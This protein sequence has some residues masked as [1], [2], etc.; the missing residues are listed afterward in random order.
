MFCSKCGNKISDNVNFCSKCGNKVSIA[1]KIEN[2]IVNN[3]DEVK[4]MQEN[5]NLSINPFN[6]YLLAYKK[7]AIFSGRSTRSEYWYFMLFTVLINVVLLGLYYYF[8]YQYED[9]MSNLFIGL[10]LCHLL[11]VFLPSLSLLVRR[12]HDANRSG[13][14]Y[15]ISFIPLI[16]PIALI[17]ALTD[18]SSDGNK[19]GHKTKQ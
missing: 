19:Y 17:I 18:K 10:Y 9:A 16:G 14:F 7:Y 6:Y 12:L 4:N 13:W 3:K 11:I 1:Y 8:D 5:N 15:F 2:E